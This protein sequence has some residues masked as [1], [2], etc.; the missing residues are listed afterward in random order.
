MRVNILKTLLEDAGVRVNGSNPW[1]IQVYNPQLYTRVWRKHSLGLGESYLD[2][3]WGCE[4]P[5][6]LLARLLK[7]NI[8]AKVRGNIIYMLHM[9]PAL[10][11]NLQSKARARIIADHH[12]DLG[13]DLFQAFLD[14]YMQYS[15]AFFDETDDL[16]QAQL[17][18]LDMICTKLDLKP[19]DHLLDI[20]CGWGG[21][22]RYAAERYGCTVTAV[23]I[24][25]EQLAFGR[26][27]CHGLPVSFMD[28]D[29]RNIKGQFDKVVSVGMFEHVGARNYATYLDVVARCL[30]PDGIFLLHT[31]GSNKTQKGGNEAWLSKYIFPN[32]EIPSIAQ[33][34]ELAEDH[35][36]IEDWHNFGPHYDKTLMAWY[37]RFQQA[38][39]ALQQNPKYDDRFKRMW[40]YY[41]LCCAAT[42]RSRQTQLWQVVMTAADSG[43]AQPLYCRKKAEHH[44]VPD[45][46]ARSRDAAA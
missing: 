1:D 12:Y 7:S 5:D 31:I 18:K 34:A 41:L 44:P 9:L 32:S 43:R 17:N 30:K 37:D 27:A 45:L 46:V 4:R 24:S 3:W 20:G 35:F 21:L 23:N 38:W 25:R 6:Q 22:A 33:I 29:Y 2:G 40:D 15:C 28:C 19:S 13:N 11:L 14:P 8:P 26:Q 42:F 10:F 36:V 16:E 39:P